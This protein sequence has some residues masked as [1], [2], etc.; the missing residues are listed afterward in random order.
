MVEDGEAPLDRLNIVSIP[1]RR[2]P[3]TSMG[4]ADLKFQKMVVPIN[5]SECGI[6]NIYITKYEISVNR[7]Y[8]RM[9]RHFGGSVETYITPAIIY[10]QCGHAIHRRTSA[11]VKPVCLPE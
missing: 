10:V 9:S 7:A 1:H 11:Q 2:P 8:N 3:A 4:K 6:I 5:I